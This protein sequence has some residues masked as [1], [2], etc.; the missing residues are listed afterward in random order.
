MGDVTKFYPKNSAENPDLVLE[1]AIGGFENVLILGWDKEGYFDARASLNL[2]G[3]DCN[4]I[5]DVFKTKLLAGD[6]TDDE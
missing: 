5:V 3:K 4:W 6:Y 1:Q 2:A